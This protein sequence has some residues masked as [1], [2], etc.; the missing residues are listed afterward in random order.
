MTDQLPQIQDSQQSLSEAQTED[1]RSKSAPASPCDQG[2]SASDHEPDLVP[3]AHHRSV[4]ADV[5]ELENI[6][7]ALSFDQR[8]DELTTLSSSSS[9]ATVTCDTLEGEGEGNSV[10]GDAEETQE[11]GDVKAAP[12]TKRMNLHDFVFIKVL[13]KGSF[14][15]VGVTSRGAPMKRPGL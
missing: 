6:R 8:G 12:E 7:K 9:I 4:W 3:S 2:M 14:G 5:K 11:N 1:D 10:S 13:G 15:K